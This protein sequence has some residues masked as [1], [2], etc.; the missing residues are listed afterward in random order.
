MLLTLRPRP[1]T[2]SI[3]LAIVFRPQILRSVRLETQ[4]G[5]HSH[6]E[7]TAAFAPLGGNQNQST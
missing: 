7:T 4:P 1:N 5:G 6:G 2:L 3:P